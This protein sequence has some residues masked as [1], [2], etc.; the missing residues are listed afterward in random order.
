MPNTADFSAAADLNKCPG[1]IEGGPV[2]HP[3][4]KSL[5]ADV[6]ILGK[7]LDRLFTQPPI[8][9]LMQSLHV[10]KMLTLQHVVA[11]SCRLICQPDDQA[12]QAV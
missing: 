11:L 2:L 12:S 3:V 1:L 5:E 8:I 6:S 4:P 10:E 7:V 9:L